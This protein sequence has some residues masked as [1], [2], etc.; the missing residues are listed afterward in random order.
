MI[1]DQGNLTIEACIRFPA[2]FT[3]SQPVGARPLLKTR[4]SLTDSRSAFRR[5]GFFKTMPDS[6]S[7]GQFCRGRLTTIHYLEPV[8]RGGSLVNWTPFVRRVVGSNPAL[9]VT[10]RDFG[11]IIHS[12]L[13][14]AFRRE[15][16][17]Q[18]SCCVGSRAP[19][20]SSGLEDVLQK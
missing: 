11:Q 2:C 1:T 14:V 9:A 17:T 8:G 16:P 18:Y 3:P 12:Q 13:P 6:S 7:A 4:S 20:N 5:C 15:T 10:Y 19:L